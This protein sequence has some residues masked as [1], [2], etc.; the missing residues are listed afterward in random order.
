MM[1]LVACYQKRVVRK[2]MENGEGE[3]SLVVV[4]YN[5]VSNDPMTLIYFDYALK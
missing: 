5:G 3:G 4:Q 1:L 2:R